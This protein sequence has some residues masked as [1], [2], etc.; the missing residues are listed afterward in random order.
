MPI[1][2]I[3]L[4]KDNSPQSESDV[5]N[6]NNE[7]AEDGNEY[8]EDN[9]YHPEE[10]DSSQMRNPPE[11]FDAVESIRNNDEHFRR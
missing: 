2:G 3:P 4:N 8:V 11:S 5:S 9:L 1:P 7:V 6:T 10:S